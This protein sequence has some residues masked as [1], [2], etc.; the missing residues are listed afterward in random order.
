MYKKKQDGRKFLSEKDLKNRQK[1]L[2]SD[3]EINAKG[4]NVISIITYV[5]IKCYR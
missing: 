3:R 2:K 4:I 1:N 5:F